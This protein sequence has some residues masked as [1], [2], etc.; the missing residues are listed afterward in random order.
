MHFL[1]D[2]FSRETRISL[3]GYAQFHDD[4]VERI[5]I[6]QLKAGLH[7]H[8]CIRSRTRALCIDDTGS[9]CSGKKCNSGFAKFAVEIRKVCRA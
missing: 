2:T 6:L 5:N 3:Y 9:W 1:V 8:P 7:I 4:F